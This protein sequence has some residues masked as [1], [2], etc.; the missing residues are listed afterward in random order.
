MVYIEER[1]QYLF[2]E[3]EGLYNEPTTWPNAFIVSLTHPNFLMNLLPFLRK[4]K[5]DFVCGRSLVQHEQ[6]K[7][8]DAPMYLAEPIRIVQV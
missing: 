7:L 5:E 8:P 2:S 6:Q 3:G 4:S 1:N